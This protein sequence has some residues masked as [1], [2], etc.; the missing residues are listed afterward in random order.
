VRH[1]VRQHFLGSSTHKLIY[2]V[3]TWA[4]TQIAICYTVVPFVVLAVGP[5]L[6]FYW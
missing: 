1:N 6:R 3:I 4:S 5:S 2:D